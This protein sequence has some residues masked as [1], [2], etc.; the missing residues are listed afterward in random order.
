FIVPRRTSCGDLRKTCC[1]SVRVCVRD[2]LL[3]FDRRLDQ[4]CG[5]LVPCM[6]QSEGPTH[7]DVA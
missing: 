7:V 3:P 4:C 2:I 5:S 1:F 6:D